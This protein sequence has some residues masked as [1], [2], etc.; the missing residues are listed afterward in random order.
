MTGYGLPPK[1]RTWTPPP[2]GWKP[3][4]LY[5]VKVAFHDANPIHD[6]YLHVGFASNNELGSYSFLWHHGYDYPMEPRHA[7]YL[8]VVKLLHEERP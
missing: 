2:E 4:C 5:L 1:E 8:E 3:M 6:A 7:H